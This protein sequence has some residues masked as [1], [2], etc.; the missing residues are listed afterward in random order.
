M[1]SYK[2]ISLDIRS[3]FLVRESFFIADSSL[4]AILLF[5]QLHKA[6]ISCGGFAFVNFAPRL[7]PRCSRKRLS[8]SV[9]IPVYRRSSRHLRIYTKYIISALSGTRCCLFCLDRS[10]FCGYRVSDGRVYQGGGLSSLP[11]R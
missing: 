8:I 3:S 1:T 2:E 9:V 11:R 5:S 7:F 10:L 4:E 6:D